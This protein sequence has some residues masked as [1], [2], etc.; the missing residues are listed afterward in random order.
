MPVQSQGP[1]AELTQRFVDYLPTLSAGLLVLVL[2]VVAGWVAKRVVIRLLIWLRLDRLGG[3]SAW[4]AA[5]GKGDVRAALYDVIGTVVMVLV[6]LVFLDNALQI[7]GLVV[8]ARMIDRLIVYVPNLA[9][10]AVIVGVG[11]LLANAAAARVEDALE[12]AEA[13]HPQLLSRVFK[14]ALLAVV[15]A[16]ALWQLAFA[17]EIVL[18]AFLIAFGSIGVAFALS[19]GVGA[20]KAIQQALDRLFEK[21]KD[22]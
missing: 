21:R 10:V 17:R 2:G 4:R 20:A 16:L 11:V 22:R 18:A 15:V 6:I 14:A 5:F 9:L 1:V 7:W 19:F 12:E 3:R 13:P 8:L